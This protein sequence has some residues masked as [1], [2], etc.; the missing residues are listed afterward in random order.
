MIVMNVLKQLTILLLTKIYK[1]IYLTT[2][3]EDKTEIGQ[4]IFT[5]N[6]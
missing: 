4:Q 2:K 3:L 1:K 6:F 5:S